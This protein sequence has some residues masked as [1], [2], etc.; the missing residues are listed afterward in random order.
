LFTFGISNLVFAFIYNKL[1]L[2]DLLN[3]GYT[4]DDPENIVSMI[5]GKVGRTIP[6][7]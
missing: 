4:T 1:Y 3:S 6:R 5:E 7:S 2:N